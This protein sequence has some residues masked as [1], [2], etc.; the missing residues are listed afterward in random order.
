VSCKPKPGAEKPEDSRPLS[1]RLQAWVDRNEAFSGAALT[2]DHPVSEA[3][4]ALVTYERNVPIVDDVKAKLDEVAVCMG[5]LREGS[6]SPRERAERV[7]DAL[8]VLW[9]GDRSP[10][11]DA[12]RRALTEAI[13]REIQEAEREAAARV[14][15]RA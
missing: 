13:V 2:P 7:G 9:E 14:G 5:V 6:A 11:I 10:L 3:V 1:E 15:G 4:R 8:A 12:V